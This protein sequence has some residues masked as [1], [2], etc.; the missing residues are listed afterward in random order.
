MLG[1]ESRGHGSAL[2]LSSD[3]WREKVGLR[4]VDQGGPSTAWLIAGA[5]VVGLGV[6]ALISMGPELRRYLKIKAM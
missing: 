5:V 2:G 4:R 3:D 1:L 6:W